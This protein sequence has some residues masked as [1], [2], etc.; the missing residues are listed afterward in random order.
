MNIII[1]KILSNIQDQ[2]RLKGLK[3]VHGGSINETF[4]I[5]TE[6]GRYFLKYHKNAPSRFFEMEKLGLQLI[7]K[8]NTISVPTVL[9]YDDQL[10]ESFLLLEWIEGE[11]TDETE[12]MLGNEIANMH[13][14]FG[15]Y[16]GFHQDTFIGLLPQPNDLFES[17]LEYYRNKRLTV[18]LKEGIKR[19]RIDHKRRDQLEKLLN[20]LDEFI[21][22]KAKPSFLHGDLWGGNWIVGP[23]GK[24]YIIDPSFLYGDRHFELAFTELFG[25]FSHR[26]Y[27]AYDQTFPVEDYYNDVKPLYQLYYLLVHLNIF[28]ESYGA[29]VDAILNTYIGS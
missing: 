20:R 17:W 26:F 18:Q 5:E 2:S 27:D 12:K 19:K 22:E 24:P 4:Y 10:G 6:K 1:K 9:A 13:Y 7:E 28:G 11:K 15:E 23:E 21:P 16:H 8:T 29:R 3:R 25:G 14:N